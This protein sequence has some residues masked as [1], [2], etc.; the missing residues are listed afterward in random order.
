MAFGEAGVCSPPAVILSAQVT[1]IRQHDVTAGFC[2]G[3]EPWQQ[4]L[5]LLLGEPWEGEGR[6]NLQ[7]C[8][9]NK[10]GLKAHPCC[11]V[12]GNP[13]RVRRV[14]YNS[15]LAFLQEQG[16]GLQRSVFA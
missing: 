9:K 13:L 3:M 4:V 8:R 1:P 5:G 10:C 16:C 15:P 7:R 2:W 6:K 12:L 11:R 14:A